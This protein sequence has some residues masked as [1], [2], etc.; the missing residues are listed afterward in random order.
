M[1]GLALFRHCLGMLH[2]TLERP[3]A[4]PPLKCGLSNTDISRNRLGL[5]TP[6]KSD[7]DAIA[8]FRGDASFKKAQ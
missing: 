5:P 8:N 1:A 6:A 2:P 3:D 7:F 4:A